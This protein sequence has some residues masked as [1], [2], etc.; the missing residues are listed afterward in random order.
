MKIAVN[1]RLLLKNNL[2]GIGWFTY[3]VMKRITKA[4]PEVE[5]YFLFDRK[6]DPSF[7]FT[8]NVKPVVLWPQARHPILYIMFFELAVPTALKKIKP[9]LFVSPDGYMSLRSEVKTLDVIHDL[10]F[11]HYPHHLPRLL[12]SYYRFFF[13]R[14]ARKAARILTV[15]EFSR[16][17]LNK[18][19]GI[20]EAKIDVVYNGVNE[21]F[22][23]LTDQRIEEIRA[24]FTEGKPFFLF[25]GSIHP[26]KNL[27]NQIKAFY[28]F[29][30]RIDE[31][32]KFLVVGSDYYR[33]GEIK[34]RI[35][36]SRYRDDVV[37]AGRRNAEELKDLYGAAFALTYVSYFEGFGIPI[38]EAMRS[39]VPVITGNASSMPE[40]GGEAVLTADP[41]SVDSIANAMAR[42]HGEEELRKRCVE[43]GLKRSREFNWDRTAEGVWEAILKTMDHSR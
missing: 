30:E 12:S 36:N 34:R 26:R 29:R 22:T 5:F 33:G 11:E 40:I 42:L 14:F 20:D 9:D 10:N 39:G 43:E 19:Y 4:H 27:L 3:E 37:F 2:D 13:P 24:E 21:D 15:S 41:D 23:P 25:V 38:V 18:E 1:T 17:D 8:D 16:K 28:A 35:E 6:P 31:E 7:I 32:F